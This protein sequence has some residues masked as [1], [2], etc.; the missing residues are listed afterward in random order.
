MQKQAKLITDGWLLWWCLFGFVV[1]LFL[2]FLIN[3][4]AVYAL[5]TVLCL[6][7]NVQCFILKS[8]NQLTALRGTIFP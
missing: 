2:F 4:V 7:I 6:L 1:V 3:M 5:E 8:Q